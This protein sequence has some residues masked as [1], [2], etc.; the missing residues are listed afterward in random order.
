MGVEWDDCTKVAKLIGVKTF[1]NEFIAFGQLSEFI[2]NR[3]SMRPG[4]V[5]SVSA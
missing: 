1:L 5:L 2:K 4:P 3:K